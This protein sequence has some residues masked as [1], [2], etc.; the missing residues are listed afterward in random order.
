MKT[1]ELPKDF[2]PLGEVE[3][4]TERSVINWYENGIFRIYAFPE[5]VHSLEDAKKQ[6]I[7]IAR[8]FGRKKVDMI[9]DIR[10]A[11][12]ISVEARNFYG[13]VEGSVNFG[14]RAIIIN[15]SF[16]RVIANFYMG[17]FKH[18]SQSKLFT[19]VKEAE[20]WIKQR[21]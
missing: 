16:G 7:F 5:I 4:H 14:K 1:K 6:S 19:N 3:T 2:S 11:P 8:K 12:P 10:D 9:L 20:K 17:I 13:S 15:S 18:S 21:D